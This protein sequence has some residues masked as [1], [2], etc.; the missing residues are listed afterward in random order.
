MCAPEQFTSLVPKYSLI[1]LINQASSSPPETAPGPLPTASQGRGSFHYL[2]T[3][4]E[5]KV[6]PTDKLMHL[7]HNQRSKSDYSNE[8]DDGYKNEGLAQTNS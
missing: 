2:F 8:G 5:M 3:V 6:V 4:H 1:T 7:I